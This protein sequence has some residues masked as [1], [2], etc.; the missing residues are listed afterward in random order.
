MQRIYPF[1]PRETEKIGIRRMDYG[2]RFHR[3]RREARI[4]GQVSTLG[5]ENIR[6][7]P[8]MSQSNFE[9]TFRQIGVLQT[10][11]GGRTDICSITTG[12]VVVLRIKAADSH[13]SLQIRPEDMINPH[14]A[15][16]RTLVPSITEIVL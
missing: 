14:V 15:I 2:F 11:L 8:V 10:C 7:I 16:M 9:I 13:R 1:H 4:G 6:G 5:T 3:E 12:F